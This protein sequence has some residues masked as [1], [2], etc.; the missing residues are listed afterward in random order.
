MPDD[1]QGNG[2]IAAFLLG[3]MSEEERVQVEVRLADEAVFR[4]VLAVEDELFDAYARG[5]LARDRR[6]R[7]E[8]RLLATA[9]QRR[10]LEFTR[11]LLRASAARRRLG[12]LRLPRPLVLVPAA[13][14]AMLAVV[15]AALFLVERKPQSVTTSA[16][17]SGEG[18]AT[19]ALLLNAERARGGEAGSGFEVPSTVEWVRLEAVVVG[20]E[21]EQYAVRVET[22]EGS[23]VW[24]QADLT[25]RTGPA[26]RV[27]SATLPSR[28]L[29]D[30]TY[31]LTVEGVLAGGSRETV[32]EYSFSIVRR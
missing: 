26:G 23:E 18:T 14:F 22:A 4:E 9:E 25:A 5:E 8:E 20:A 28:L 10:K 3:E 2:W 21:Q 12:W 17:A 11:A 6:R 31:V 13:A 7:F 27:V 30:R 16:P 24:S 19:L 15:A 29:T 1:P 32:A